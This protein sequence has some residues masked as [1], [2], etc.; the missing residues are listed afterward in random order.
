M[1][2]RV[3]RSPSA[4]RRDRASDQAAE[5]AVERVVSAAPAAQVTDRLADDPG[6]RDRL[7]RRVFAVLC[8]LT[9]WTATVEV[10]LVVLQVYEHEEM[11]RLASR[12]QEHELTLVAP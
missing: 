9:V 6:W 12:Q 5:G 2:P 10:R 1:I 8:L 3:F 7:K 11:L 4:T